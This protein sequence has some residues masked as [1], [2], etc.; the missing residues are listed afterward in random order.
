MYTQDSYNQWF[1]DMIAKYLVNHEVQLSEERHNDISYVL[2]TIKHPDNNDKNIVIST[3]GNEITLF[4]CSSHSHH[5]NDS[6][7]EQFKDLVE[8]IEDIK[9]TA[10]SSQAPA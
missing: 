10:S 4:F 3:Y 6:H 9:M 8:Y 1:I 5:D 2:A 7:E